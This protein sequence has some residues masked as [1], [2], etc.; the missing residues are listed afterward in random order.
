MELVRCRA[1]RA[2]LV[3]IEGEWDYW[4][5]DPA[6]KAIRDG[7]IVVLPTDSCYTFAAN[8]HSREAVQSIYSLKGMTDPETVKPL[9]LLCHSISQISEFTRGVQSKAAFK[10]LKQTLPGPYT[11]IL[12]ASSSLPRIIIEHKEHKKSW[13]RKE[14]GVRIP[15]DDLVLEFLRL[16]DTPV[17]CSSVP[18]ERGGKQLATDSSQIS[19]V[20]GDRVA[21]IVDAGI[22]NNEPSTVVDLTSEDEIKILRHGAGDVEIFSPYLKN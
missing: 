6:V 14:I 12:P 9:S 19:D 18:A 10:L 3:E 15:K 1:R 22:R 7:E 2:A 4:K 13:K 20:W 17:L 16:L 21:F 8:L 11:F 5:L